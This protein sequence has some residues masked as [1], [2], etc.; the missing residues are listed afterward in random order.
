MY[1]FLSSYF[2]FF[3][4]ISSPFVFFS[5]CSFFL[6]GFSFLRGPFTWSFRFLSSFF[7]FNSFSFFLTFYFVFWHF[8]SFFLLCIYV[9]CVS[10]FLSFFLSFFPFSSVAFPFVQWNS[11]YTQFKIMPCRHELVFG[12]K[13]IFML[14]SQ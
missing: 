11:S 1:P 4:L 8:F 5:Y 3:S 9:F 14:Y 2:L 6:M 13:T 7:F 10:F 12:T